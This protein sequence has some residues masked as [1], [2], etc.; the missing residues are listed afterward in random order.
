MIHWLMAKKRKN[1]NYQVAFI[2]WLSR[3]NASINSFWWMLA[4]MSS[5]YTAARE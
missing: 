4:A 3:D 1:K 5:P 2:F